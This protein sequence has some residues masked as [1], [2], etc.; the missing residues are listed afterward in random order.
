MKRQSGNAGMTMWLMPNYLRPDGRWN[1]KKL[2]EALEYA[3]DKT[4]ITKALGYG[5]NIP[6]NLICPPGAMGYDASLN[7]KYDPA[8]AKLLIAEAG[9]REPMKVKILTE[10]AG[11]DTSAAIK[12]YLD[13]V[14]FQCEID[15][16]DSA[17]YYNSIYT[18]G[19]EDI[20]FTGS[21]ID[22]NYLITL[23]DWFGPKS[24]AKMP[25][26]VRPQAFSDLWNQAILKENRRDQE[27]LT[28]KMVKYIH[29]EALICPLYMLPVAVMTQ[30]Y[31]HT[32]YI[33]HGLQRWNVAE[34]WL[35]KH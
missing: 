33:L 18:N 23:S 22:P 13:A 34:D 5:Y 30:P 31:A 10:N 1:N 12:G 21:G 7:R 28:A 11:R 29:D 6:M 32:T 14:G 25:S 24:R 20:C 27:I 35:G 2:R 16:A 4:A 19:W 17:R 15:V 26:W 3:I 8:K 9:Y